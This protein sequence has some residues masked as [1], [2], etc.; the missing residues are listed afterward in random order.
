MR[1]KYI[2]AVLLLF[3]APE[4]HSQNSQVLYF[5]D[6]P[7]NHLLN[8]AFRP[9]NK[10]YIGLPVLS[11]V[12][13]NIANSVFNFSDVFTEGVEVSESSIPFTNSD[14]D[15]DKFM[16][17]IRKFNYFETQASIQLLGFGLALRNDLYFFMDITDHFTSNIVIPRDFFELA[18]RGNDKF[19]GSNVDL[20]NMGFNLKY[21]REAGF[22]VS[23]NI[24]NKIRFGAKGKLLFGIA[25]ASLQNDLLSINVVDDNSH[26]FNTEMTLNVSGPVRFFPESLVDQPLDSAGFDDER[27]KSGRDYSRFLTNTKNLGFGFDVGAEFKVTDRLY[28]SLAITDLGFIRWKSDVSSLKTDDQIEFGGL[29]MEEVYNGTSSF[30]DV[31]GAMIDSIKNSI[32]IAGSPKPFTTIL[33]SGF[34]LAGK[35]ELT[36][37]FSVGLLSYSKLT[38]KQVREALTLSANLNLGGF[39][40][41]TLAYT[42]CNRSYNNLGFG[43]AI[44]GL[45]AQLYFMV[46]KIPLGWSK[47][48]FGSDSFPFPDRWDTINTRIGFNLVFGNKNRK[49]K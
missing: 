32:I 31:G 11:G 48:Q 28:A 38:G 35:Y 21:Y 22:G 12:N 29:N 34:S 23:K 49:N 10:I 4:V 5:M 20:T 3:I 24:G 45:Y 36:N 27:F 42:A 7:Q 26:T 39:F 33:P 1:A 17:R 43:L 47:A 41:T 30:S 37:Y 25:A 18:F 6:L 9:S 40:S 14:Y 19:F 44:R 13:L 8:P 2:L 46:D 15:L 16:S